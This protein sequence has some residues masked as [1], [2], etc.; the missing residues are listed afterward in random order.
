MHAHVC[1]LLLKCNCVFLTGAAG[2]GKTYT[3]KEVERFFTKLEK[4]VFITA[5]T[6]IAA[7][8]YEKG[9]T[10]HSFAGLPINNKSAKD[11]LKHMHAEVKE[12]IKRTDLL[13][14]DEVSML[15][16]DLLQ[17]V[18]DLF[19]N[20][21]ENVDVM[22]GGIMV[23]LAG[24]FYQLPPVDCP[25]I[26]PK[27]DVWINC[28]FENVTLTKNFRQSEDKDFQRALQLLRIGKIN[29]TVHDFFQ[30]KTTAK[31]TFNQD[32]LRVFFT[33]KET[34]A[35]NT[36]RMNFLQSEEFT[37]PSVVEKKQA[38]FMPP[39]WPFQ[40]PESV[41]LKEGCRVMIIRNLPELHL[42]NGD[43]ALVQDIDV[44]YGS[45]TLIVN[46][47]TM[48]FAMQTETLLNNNN[49]ILAQCTGF[50]LI[51][52][53][54]LTVHKVQG[55]NLDAL[56]VYV[57]KKQFVPHLFYVA[58]SRVKKSQNLH[59]IS[60]P[61]FL[62]DFLAQIKIF[63]DVSAFYKQLAYQLYHVIMDEKLSLPY[64]TTDNFYFE[65]IEKNVPYAQ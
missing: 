39:V 63:Q 4:N 58:V 57:N 18:N 9:M 60:Q 31:D 12:R 50:P 26:L 15:T 21:K 32:Y 3:I 47:T 6:A 33:K 52:A 51:L 25:Y 5:T 27:H 56:V 46:N 8:N 7:R 2:T 44:E 17:L 29:D 10:L 23:L 14:I 53:Y 59:I 11:V 13:I 24:D 36:T 41:L 20:I 28:K 54:G 48:S 43:F 38:D 40:T 35:Y 64:F 34:N 42:V 37:F 65:K 16:G 22:F 45:L 19:K 61:H 55:L 1:S 30:K 49:E 62:T